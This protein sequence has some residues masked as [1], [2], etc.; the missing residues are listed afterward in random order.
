M[1]TTAPTLLYPNRVE[2]RKLIGGANQFI[3]CN[4]KEEIA[5]YDAIASNIPQIAGIN[6]RKLLSPFCLFKHRCPR[7]LLSIFH[8]VMMDANENEK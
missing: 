2:F 6:Y 3:K 1:R 8:L 4:L 5:K 7:S